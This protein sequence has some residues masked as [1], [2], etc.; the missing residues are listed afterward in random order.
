MSLELVIH[1]DREGRLLSSDILNRTVALL[2]LHS[3]EDVACWSLAYPIFL[4]SLGC[5]NIFQSGV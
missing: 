5:C 1:L 2:Q 3:Q 4:R